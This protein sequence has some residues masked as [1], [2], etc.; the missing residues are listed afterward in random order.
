MTS[1]NPIKSL[2]IPQDSLELCCF[3]S[4]RRFVGSATAENPHRRSGGVPAAAGLAAR[5]DRA[6]HRPGL[7]STPGL[8][9]GGAPQL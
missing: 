1:P 2:K 7:R 6:D 4:G 5:P 3:S 9:Q 8:M